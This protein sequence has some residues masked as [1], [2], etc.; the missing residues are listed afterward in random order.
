MI[1][2]NYKHYSEENF[3]KKITALICAIALTAT[4]CGSASASFFLPDTYLIRL[5]LFAARYIR[6]LPVEKAPVPEKAE[7]IPRG[8]Y[9]FVVRAEQKLNMEKDLPY[10]E[11]TLINETG[12]FTVRTVDDVENYNFL[13]VLTPGFIGRL[14]HL[15]NKFIQF[16]M[17]KTDMIQKLEPR[18]TAVSKTFSTADGFYLVNITDERRGI[19]SFY[20]TA[21]DVTVGGASLSASYSDKGVA[22]ITI[23]DG[24][25]SG[26]TL[27]KIARGETEL[28]EGIGNA[29]I[30]MYKG[31]IIRVFSFPDGYEA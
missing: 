25:Y 30:Q 16:D 2:Y 18:R 20:D 11:L 21:K 26:S 13:P 22:I 19:L 28:S 14:T 10:A 7:I 27:S 12:V 31:D 9:A 5:P 3:M 8:N 6:T 15:E 23:E 4:L 1:P 29:V 24:E 17:R